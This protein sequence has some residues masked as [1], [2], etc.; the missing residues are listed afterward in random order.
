MANKPVT[1]K[2]L[3]PLTPQIHES[4]K[5]LLE[6]HCALSKSVKAAARDK[7]EICKK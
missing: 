7:T 4:H 1:L 2:S 5:T 3:V 6:G